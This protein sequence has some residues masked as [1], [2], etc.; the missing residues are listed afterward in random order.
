MFKDE[1]TYMLTK[2]TMQRIKIL[3]R[4]QNNI[5]KMQLKS[6]KYQNK[7][8]KNASQLKKKNKIFLLTKNLKT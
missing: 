6:T 3:K 1:Q 4:I 7:K 5:D 2:T 8:R